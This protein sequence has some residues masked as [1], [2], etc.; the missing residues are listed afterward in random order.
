MNTLL[1]H[2]QYWSREAKIYTPH[3]TNIY[4]N[5]HAQGREDSFRDPEISEIKQLCCSDKFCSM[6][7]WVCFEVGEKRTPITL[8]H[9][10]LNPLCILC[11]HSTSLPRHLK[12]VIIWRS[13]QFLVFPGCLSRFWERGRVP[14][15]LPTG[16]R[17]N[18]RTRYQNKLTNT[19]TTKRPDTS[20]NYWF[21]TLN[22]SIMTWVKYGVGYQLHQRIKC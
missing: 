12:K 2:K 22:V 6:W 8:W 11:Q 20:A 1:Q 18:V 5:V 19:T 9:S 4:R 10:H 15:D 17:K 7:W 16:R 14:W 13:V 3:S 21:D